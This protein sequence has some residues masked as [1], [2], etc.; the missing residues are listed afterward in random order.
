MSKDNNF[1]QLKPVLVEYFVSSD[2]RGYNTVLFDAE[3]KTQLGVN[4]NIVQI[5]QGFSSRS[6]TLRGLHYQEPPYD[7]AK[8]CYCLTGSVFNVAVNL[9]NGEITAAEL[10]PGTVMY[11]PRGYAHGYLT[12][13][14]DTLFQ[15]CVD[16]DFCP[17]KARVVRYDSCGIDWPVEDWSNV[18]I[19]DK[20]KSGVP[21]M[22]TY[23]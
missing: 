15:W 1:E 16:N 23:I 8:L 20:D 14:P 10:Q 13:E 2:N 21:L 11:I 5:N 6:Y 18:I 3:L 12:L 9:K 17:E 4:F 19:S 7:Q 22:D